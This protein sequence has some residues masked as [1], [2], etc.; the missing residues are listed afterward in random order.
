MRTTAWRRLMRATLF[1]LA[2]LG[3]LAFAQDDG[4]WIP[5]VA[6]VNHVEDLLRMMPPPAHGAVKADPFDSYGRYYVGQTDAGKKQI[7]ANFYSMNPKTWPPG[8][9]IGP[10]DQMLMGGGCKHILML[11]DVAEDHIKLFVCYGLG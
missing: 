10:A 5:D 7:F 6:T 3:S 2:A 1:C 11:Y 8:M 9:H 4:H